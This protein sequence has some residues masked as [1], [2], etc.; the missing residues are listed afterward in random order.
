MGNEQLIPN[1]FESTYIDQ[2][3]EATVFGDVANLSFSDKI[4]SESAG[5]TITIPIDP[6]ISVKAWAGGS[7]DTSDQLQAGNVKLKINEGLQTR[8]HWK[9]TDEI[10][11]VKDPKWA[12]KQV[13]KVNY[14]M[15]NE[16]DKSFANLYTEAGTVI[17]MSNGTAVAINYSNALALCIEAQKRLKQAL[18]GDLGTYE[19]FMIAS[20]AFYANVLIDNKPFYTESARSEVY[21]NGKLPSKLLSFDVYESNNVKTSGA[22]EYV[23]FGVK[24][25]ALAGA[26]QKD[27]T[28]MSNVPDGEVYTEYKSAGL[29][30]VGCIDS[31]YLGV[32]KITPASVI[33]LTAA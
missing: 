7:L 19:L 23:Y 33:N 21:K 16:I 4:Q 25:L 15:A 17:Q 11:M 14:G 6:E 27:M 5:D 29:Y 32:A 31:R 10:Q 12:K 24:K 8:F 20:P 26:V 1:I 3:Y 2:I 13:K 18:G 9:K 30:G 28:L 22:D